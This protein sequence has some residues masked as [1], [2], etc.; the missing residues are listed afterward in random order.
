ME[1]RSGQDT[2]RG[3]GK[4]WPGSAAAAGGA[5]SLAAD[6]QRRVSGKSGIWGSAC[7]V[8]CSEPAPDL[9]QHFQHSPK[10]LL[11]SQIT[12]LGDSIF[13]SGGGS[14]W[15]GGVVTTEML[16]AS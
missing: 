12:L 10:L 1:A 2:V 16:E 5:K 14:L 3:S 11:L 7:P 6:V 13:P 15:V 8:G 9:Q 4:R